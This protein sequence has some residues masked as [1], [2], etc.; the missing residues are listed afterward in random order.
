MLFKVKDDAFAEVLFPT[1]LY[2]FVH[3]P[4][5]TLGVALIVVAP[6]YKVP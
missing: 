2:A 1:M 6:R 5:D 3:V 4:A